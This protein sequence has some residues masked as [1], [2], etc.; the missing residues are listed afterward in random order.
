MQYKKAV[1]VLFVGMLVHIG[2]SA[3]QITRIAVI[4]LQKVYM[5]YYKDSQAV[6]NFEEEKL[7]IQQEI[8]KMSDEIRQLEQRR[9]ELERAGDY[10]TA[11]QLVQQLVQ[12]IQ[13]LADY[14]RIK[15][16]EIDEKGRNLA[17]TNT[18]VQTLHRTITT[19]AE[20]EG[21][22]VVLS[23]RNN[24]VVVVWFSSMI[25][26]TDKVIQALIGF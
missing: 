14:R 3:Q 7:R 15:Q 4:D 19:V 11:Q 13:F 1:L 8:Q 9:L 6:R 10:T 18:F 21:Y 5:T 12:K 20:G 26:I 17:E 16:N 24:D 25:D 2:L 22:S 23:S